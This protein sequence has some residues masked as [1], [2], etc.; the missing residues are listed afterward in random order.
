MLKK[1]VGTRHLLCFHNSPKYLKYYYNNKL[2]ESY[3]LV[4]MN[5]ASFTSKNKNS[6]VYNILHDSD[7]KMIANNMIVET[8]CRHF[9]SHLSCNS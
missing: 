1:C 6:Y 7:S 8:L 4:D 5:L 9:H 3:K 2:I